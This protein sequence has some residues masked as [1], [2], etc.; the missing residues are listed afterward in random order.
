MVRKLVDFFACLS[1]STHAVIGGQI[2]KRTYE[3]PQLAAVGM[4][5]KATAVLLKKGISGYH[6]RPAA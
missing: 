5:S 6:G 3:K 4:L 1:E 2:V